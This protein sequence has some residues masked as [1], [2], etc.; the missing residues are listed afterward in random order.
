MRGGGLP[1]CEDGAEI[2]EQKIEISWGKG[3][4][5]NQRP[6]MSCT[7]RS[8]TIWYVDIS[9]EETITLMS[10]ITYVSKIMTE[11]DE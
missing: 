7:W 2:F 10:S 4:P 11:N 5:T 6:A 1:E 3:S 8:S 9:E